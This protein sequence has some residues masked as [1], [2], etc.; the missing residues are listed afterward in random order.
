M[1][2]SC[3]VVGG[4][5]VVD[6]D[7][8][9]IVVADTVVVVAVAAEPARYPS[10]GPD[11]KYPHIGDFIEDRLQ[12]ADY[13][14]SAPPYDSVREYQYEGSASIN[15]SLSSLNSSSSASTQ[16]YEYL[17][18][19]GPRFAKLAEMYGGGESEEDDSSSV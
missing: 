6:A 8:V 13:D 14:G 5:V 4:T 18:N 19:W 9:V 12:D 10:V 16:D 11:G 1:E 17:N 3:S 2:V 15:G 7:T